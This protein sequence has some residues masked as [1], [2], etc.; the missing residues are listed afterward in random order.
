[1]EPEIKKAPREIPIDREV[2]ETEHIEK[3]GKTYWLS[4]DKRLFNSNEKFIGWLEDGVYTP[5]PK[6]QKIRDIIDA[7]ARK[8]LEEEKL[9]KNKLK[10]EDAI[11]K[12]M[13]ELR[14]QK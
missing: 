10:L 2:I 8:R 11:K 7:E 14:N 5:S 9:L 12:R 1:M 6:I 13:N 4:A 3:N